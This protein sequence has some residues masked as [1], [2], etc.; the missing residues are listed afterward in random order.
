MEMKGRNRRE[1]T[2][3]NDAIEPRFF[4]LDM[5]SDGPLALKLIGERERLD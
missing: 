2:G 3:K 4:V 1:G 5:G